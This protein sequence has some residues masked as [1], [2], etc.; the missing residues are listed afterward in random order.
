[1]S[2]ARK[3]QTAFPQGVRVIATDRSGDS[4]IG[5]VDRLPDDEVK[6]D[7]Q[8]EMVLVKAAKPRYRGEAYWFEF[9]EVRL[10]HLPP[11]EELWA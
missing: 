5:L 4:L 8:C 10:W 6:Y 11:V 7:Y 1:M 2:D 3:Q 9:S